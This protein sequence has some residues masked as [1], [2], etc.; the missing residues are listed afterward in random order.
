[1]TFLMHFIFIILYNK[2]FLYCFAEIVVRSIHMISGNGLFYSAKIY[3]VDKLF[4]AY[5]LFDKVRRVF[6]KFDSAFI[7]WLPGD[8]IVF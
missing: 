6:H 4:E 2:N 8:S 1:M 3:N 5:L 7:L